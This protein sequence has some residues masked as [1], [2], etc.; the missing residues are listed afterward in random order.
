MATM[1][2]IRQQLLKKKKIFLKAKE[3]IE[4]KAQQQVRKT[5]LWLGEHG[6]E[7]RD[8]WD[9]FIEVL[10]QSLYDDTAVVVE[11]N[12]KYGWTFASSMGLTVYINDELKEK[13]KK[14]LDTY[15]YK[16]YSEDDWYEYKD[17]KEDI[18]EELEPK[19]VELLDDC[20]FLFEN[21]K[22]K[23][24][25]PVLFSIIEGEIAKTLDTDE[26][27]WKLKK[28]L[29]EQFKVEPNRF[30]KIGMYSVMVCV[31]QA[32]FPNSK[33]TEERKE[34]INRNWVLHGRDDP[35]LWEVVD[36][37]RLL[38]VLNS[39]QYIQRLSKEAV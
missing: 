32:L 17:L 22:Y 19:W 29:K 3:D 21:G 38:T 35:R 33:F 39:I 13:S 12:S 7:N 14:E 1:R 24:A 10:A 16:Y 25:V 28:E 30:K 6:I 23:T 27:G 20:F 34:V 5:K 26:Y 18:K 36:V 4:I 2:E 15:F 9:N 31:D 37:L 8:D 11:N